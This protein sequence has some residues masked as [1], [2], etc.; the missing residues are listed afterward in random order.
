MDSIERFYATIERRP[1]DHPASWMGMPTPEAIP[2]LLEYFEVDTFNELKA[3]HADDFYAVEWAIEHGLIQQA[4]T[5]LQEH[6]ITTICYLIGANPND[7]FVRKAV[8]QGIVVASR[9]TPEYR[10][11]YNS[12]D[13]R[14]I[15]VG[16]VQV[17]QRNPEL[18]ASLRNLGILRNSMNHAESTDGVLITPIELTRD[19]KRLSADL[20]LFFENASG[21]MTLGK[22]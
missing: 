14:E 16:T 17:L 13:Q 11:R 20:K 4:C 22:L 19:I 6:V 3:T 7:R 21:L 10:W 18:I 1:V 5:M 8:N 2:A 9:R 12:D 15:M